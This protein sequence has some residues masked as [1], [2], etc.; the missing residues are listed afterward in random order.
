MMAALAGSVGRPLFKPEMSSV[1]CKETKTRRFTSK[2]SLEF[3]DFQETHAALH[4]WGGLGAS[5]FRAYN[6]GACQHVQHLYL[7]ATPQ[8]QPP[9]EACKAE[10]QEVS[11]AQPQGV[12]AGAPD[13]ADALVG[14]GE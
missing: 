3:Q 14:W 1:S 6:I 9:L 8:H 2:E 10:A 11:E 12:R 5:G 7:R 4:I 13:G